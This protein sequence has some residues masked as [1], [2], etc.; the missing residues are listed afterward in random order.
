[1]PR[2][3]VRKKNY[4]ILSSFLH[5]SSR[6]RIWDTVQYFLISDRHPCVVRA[7]QSLRSGVTLQ[8]AE[9]ANSRRSSK[10][11]MSSPGSAAAW[12]NRRL[13]RSNRNLVA[14]RHENIEIE[15]YGGK[16]VDITPRPW[17]LL[18]SRCISL[19]LRSPSSSTSRRRR[20]S[21]GSGTTTTSWW[22]GARWDA[23]IDRARMR[24]VEKLIEFSSHEG[25]P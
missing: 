7:H 22:Q 1:M 4:T 14:I 3:S 2:I 12:L 18:F 21:S 5:L 11:I 15:R 23:G 16:V 13:V 9:D 24:W 6:H 19:F 20:L 8:S 25:T 17:P 10:M